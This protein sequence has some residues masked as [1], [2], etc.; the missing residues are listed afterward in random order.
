MGSTGMSGFSNTSNRSWLRTDRGVETY[1]LQGPD[2]PR[3]PHQ[4]AELDYRAQTAPHL[5]RRVP[6]EPM[7]PAQ[8]WWLREVT[9]D[10]SLSQGLYEVTTGLVSLYPMP[11]SRSASLGVLRAGTRFAG[12]PRIVNGAVWIKVK[13]KGVSPPLFSNRA[14][15]LTATC[16]MSQPVH[17]LFASSGVPPLAGNEEMEQSDEIWLEH[18]IQY[19]VRVRD[20][21][22]EKGHNLF[23]LT[24]N[25]L[26]TRGFM[27][28]R[29]RPK[30]GSL[31]RT[32]SSPTL[33]TTLAP[34]Q[35]EEN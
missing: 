16:D 23:H 12:T 26:N 13:T 11:D 6:S 33:G 31:A 32:A 4:L 10:K 29:L 5:L 3:L 24:A 19:V 8:R 14:D 2:S 21:G 22:K 34:D 28:K 25:P 20:F 27:R 18:N 1:A 30:L 9:H 15:I 35:A 7:K 17:R